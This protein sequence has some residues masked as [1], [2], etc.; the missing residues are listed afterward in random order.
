MERLQARV[1]GPPFRVAPLTFEEALAEAAAGRPTIKCESPDLG[2]GPS[3]AGYLTVQ[4]WAFSPAGIE[5][6]EVTV[7]GGEPIEIDYGRSR[8]DIATSLGTDDPWLGYAMRL[9][10]TPWGQGPHQVGVIA[11][12]RGGNRIGQMGTVTV[13]PHR[14]YRDWLGRQLS[15]RAEGPATVEVTSSVELGRTLQRL[16][17]RGEGGHVVVDGGGQLD[18]SAPAKLGAALAGGADLAYG[19]EDAIVEDG[20]RGADYLKP[21]WSPELLLST[22]YVGPVVAVSAGAA[23]MAL[24]HGE[25]PATIN[26]LCLRLLDAPIRVERVA[27]VLYTANHPRVPRETPGAAAEIR[28][29]GSRLGFSPRI[30]QAPVPG[31]RHVGWE[32]DGVPLVSL[33]I[34]TALAG[35]L[36][37]R[38]L[39]SIHLRTS[40]PN[41]EV[42]I[43]DSSGG[44]L[45]ADNTILD[46]VRHTVVRYRG[47]FNYS[48]AINLGAAEARGDYL[49]F[50]NDDTEARA[51]DWLERMLEHA[52]LPGVGVVGAK[53]LFPD[54][55]IQHGGVNV[56]P[57][58]SGA[59]HLFALLPGDHPGYRGLLE[60]TRNVSAVTGA[61]M[62]MPTALFGELGGFDEGQRMEYGDT[63]ICLRAV[64]KGRRVVWT[65]RA[66]LWH[67][68]NASRG[69]RGSPA[70]LERFHLRWRGTY[71]RGDPYYP[72]AFSPQFTYEYAT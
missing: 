62:M 3:V 5:R 39:E 63:D 16:A 23:T 53:L 28:A 60:L 32:I 18:P 30:E 67:H 57:Q 64:E 22:D 49:V 7:D 48:R 71:A 59:N 46:G 25:P 31:A 42:V 9:D 34:P 8:P 54:R 33:V 27:S 47:D 52:Q 21:A 2:R 26:E 72:G 65:P 17:D 44:G 61:C 45:Q 10:A 19:D 14:P 51:E 38:C 24:R 68:E 56:I 4:G 58:A 1:G 41:L 11:T 66:V 40:Y 29:L 35:G 15:V 13:S 55:R 36:L 43:V 37:H 70:D 6:I 20:G 12:D 69:R 50:L